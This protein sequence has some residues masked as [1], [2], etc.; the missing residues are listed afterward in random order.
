MK[1]VPAVTILLI[2]GCCALF[3]VNRGPCAGQGL[4]PLDFMYGLFHPVDALP[5]AGYA[6]FCSLFV[7]ASLF[8][9]VSNMWYLWLFGPAM[10]LR[11]GALRFGL[12]YLIAGIVATTIQA[13]SSP[14]STI[15]IVGAS[16]AI[17]G[18]MGLTLMLL[19]RSKLVCYFPPVFF[20]K[21]PS[22]VFLLLWLCIQ[23]INL[24]ASTAEKN[25]IAWWAHIGGFLFG[26]TVGI[27]FHLHTIRIGRLKKRRRAN[28]R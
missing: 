4:V 1:R 11:L 27:V 6:L 26:V 13:A 24:S 21:I 5:P 22:F 19:P 3:L 9:C 15:P 23:Y 16:G 7:H 2:A 10:E 20:F 25:L 12:I 17:A 18:I 8:H 28:G 14:L